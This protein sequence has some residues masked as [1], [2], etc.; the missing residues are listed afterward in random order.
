[1]RFRVL[2]QYLEGTLDNGRAFSVE[3]TPEFTEMLLK[4]ATEKHLGKKVKEVR[5]VY[6]RSPYE[7]SSP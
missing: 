4:E 2:K 6:K 3:V 5:I 1:M 7:L